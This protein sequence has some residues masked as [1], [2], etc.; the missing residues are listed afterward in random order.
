M[1]EIEKCMREL[2]R[3][4]ALVD[5]L[6]NGADFIASCTQKTGGVHLQT[7]AI[8]AGSKVREALVNYFTGWALM[9]AGELKARVEEWKKAEAKGKAAA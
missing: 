3:L 6:Q 5:G 9:R 2:Q 8:P 1:T 4:N 7:L